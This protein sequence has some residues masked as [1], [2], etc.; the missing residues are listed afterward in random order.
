MRSTEAK[1]R[2]LPLAFGQQKVMSRYRHAAFIPGWSA[3][4]AL[5][6]HLMHIL[7]QHYHVYSLAQA[8]VKDDMAFLEHV[9]F[10]HVTNDWRD[11]IQSRIDVPTAMFTG[12]HS[13]W[14]DCQRWMNTIIAG[15]AL[16]VYRKA[17]QGDH[18]QVLRPNRAITSRF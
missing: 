2:L 4:G 9:L 8:A 6:F 17:E 7:S 5:Y 14:L 16:H 1:A 11:V 13:D 3:N 12:E 10:D 18:F 15:S